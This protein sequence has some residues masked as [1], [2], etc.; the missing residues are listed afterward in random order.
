MAMSL[1]RDQIGMLRD[2]KA[3]LVSGVHLKELEEN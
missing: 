2:D 3:P 1:M